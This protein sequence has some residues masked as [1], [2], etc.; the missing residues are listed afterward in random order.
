MC[1]WPLKNVIVFE[2]IMYSEHAALSKPSVRTNSRSIGRKTG[3]VRMRSLT[4]NTVG[5]DGVIIT[6][7]FQIIII[8]II[9]RTRYESTVRMKTSQLRIA[10]K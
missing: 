3:E 7:L 5:G 6:A 1:E 9:T 4:Y 8:I 10:S 2:Y